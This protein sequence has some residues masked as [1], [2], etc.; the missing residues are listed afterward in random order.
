MIRSKT[1]RPVF[2]KMTS[3][4]RILE[5]VAIVLLLLTWLIAFSFTFMQ[6]AHLLYFL[7][8]TMATVF[9]GSMF[10]TARFPGKLRIKMPVVFNDDAIVPQSAMVLRCIRWIGVAFALQGY[11]FLWGF[12][13]LRSEELL[14]YGILL[15]SI[16]GAG[17]LLFMICIFVYYIRRVNRLNK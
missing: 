16:G 4:D 9:S 1:V 10:M 12:K 8:A 17:T 15:F 6:D 2:V 14:N 11:F 7:F 5:S 13:C 3:F